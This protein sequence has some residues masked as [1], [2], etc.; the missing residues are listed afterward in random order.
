MYTRDLE[1]T[2]F[3][4]RMDTYTRINDNGRLELPPAA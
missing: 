2:D 3:A 4:S 1:I